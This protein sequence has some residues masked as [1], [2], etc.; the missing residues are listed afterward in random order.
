MKRCCS[1][2]LAV[3]FLL[4]SGCCLKTVAASYLGVS[5]EREE[6]TA[7]EHTP[8]L[9]E[10]L[11]DD[12][13]EI[14][15]SIARTKELLLRIE[16]REIS[17]QNAQRL[18]DAIIDVYRQSRTAASVAYVRYCFDMTDESK[19]AAY[20]QLSDRL[21]ELGCLLIDAEL[22]LSGDPELSD[23]YDEQAIALL[24]QQ[25]AMHDLSVK[26]SEE[27][28]RK[29][30]GD[31]DALE[32]LTVS[33]AGRRWTKADIFSD[34]A[35]TYN[36]FIALWSL[37]K[38]A[39]NAESG[40]IFLEMID[41]R[42]AMAQML[43]FTSYAEYGYALY[44]RDYT[45]EDAKRLAAAVKR[46]IVP[47]FVELQEPFYHATMR[48]SSGRFLVPATLSNVRNAVTALLPEFEEP[49]TYMTEHGMY[50]LEPGENKQSGSFTTYFETY[51]A[52]FLFTSWDGS[53]EM[54]TTMIHEFGH[55]A[56]Y[57]LNGV[58]RMESQDPLDLAE[59]DSQG[60]ELLAL[61]QYDTL[62]G[63]LAD[64]AKTVALTIAC[65][66]V[67]TGCMEDE[68]QQFA[69]RTKDVTLEQLNA[70]YG[71]LVREYGLDTMSVDG[72]SWT[73]IAHTFRAPMYY[74]S[75]A[76]S[77]LAAMQLMLRYNGDPNGAIDSYRT[78]LMR[79]FGATFRDTVRQAGLSDPFADGVVSDITD[80]LRA[81]ASDGKV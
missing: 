69:Y 56:G 81:F 60:L 48:L 13:P 54:P 23:V 74:I 62:Y 55:Y 49:W 78:I 22:A 79:P 52:P 58:Q 18:V 10:D 50:D 3:L 47:L 67:I 72:E 21:N 35:L 24:K 8:L 65:Y 2:L 36:D 30:I 42:N 53:Y 19:R 12:A 27:R 17:G 77:M 28:E 71:R 59:I 26:E 9:F 32:T 1:L 51:G 40:R 39:Y 61:S 64:A 46:E 31:Y 68:F 66:A 34:P 63:A 41:V 5:I 4:S 7:H 29:L 70:E 43:G 6:P 33:Y 20:E 45:P 38:S 15:L 76:V 44:A 57:Y 16:R 14:G 80:A 73:E 11:S 25:N 75:Y 37:Y